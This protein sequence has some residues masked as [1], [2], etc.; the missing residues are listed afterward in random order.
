MPF[1]N[2]LVLAILGLLFGVRMVELTA[3]GLKLN[4]RV[5]DFTGGVEIGIEDGV[6]PDPRVPFGVSPPLP[7]VND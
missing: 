6:R 5:G 7:G 2:I 1:D 3:L 4:A